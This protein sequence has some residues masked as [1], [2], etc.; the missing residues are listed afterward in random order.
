MIWMISA[1]G[2]IYDHA[3]SF[4]TNGFIDWRQRARY[5]NGDIVYIYCTRPFMRVMYKCEVVQHSMPFSECIDDSIFW[6]DRD[7][8][9]KSKVGE[10]ARLKLLEQ[11]DTMQLC[12]DNLKRH[13]LSAAPQGPIKVSAQL[14]AYIEKYF[15]DY[16]TD[17]FFSDIS[18]QEHY[19]EGHV[20]TV[21]VDKYERS[22]IA[23]GKCI[24][25]YGVSCLICGINFGEEY[26]N[27]GEG[28][29][30]IHHM[31]PLHTIRKDYVVDY[32]KDLI[33]V[34]PN[35]HAMIH[36]L[37]NNENMSI[38]EIKIALQ[39]NT[40]TIDIISR[41]KQQ[42]IEA[43]K[44][45]TQFLSKITIGCG[46]SHKK[47]GVGKIIKLDTQQKHVVVSFDS[48]EKTFM[49]DAF[50]KKFLLLI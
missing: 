50:D 27:L 29:I 36:R 6:I 35:C 45:Q 49:M 2:K 31:R 38:G 39:R 25:Y 12:L 48:G 3:S 17:G 7:E 41:A 32:K 43:S 42:P 37:P 40:S 14:N 18:E 10:Y 19:H 46:V 34:C 44:R 23:R 33:P 21:L 24:E 22:S 4:A 20:R 47:Y 5:N 26:G 1:N 11:V 9:E 15:N 13:G 30:H 16:Y 8:Y 28:F